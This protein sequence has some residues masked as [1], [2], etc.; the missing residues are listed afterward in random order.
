MYN[1]DIEF[2]ELKDEDIITYYAQLR[3][4]R[5]G[6]IRIERENLHGKHVIHNYGHGGA[7][8]SLAPSCSLEAV[9]LALDLIKP[10]NP[11]AIIGSGISGLMVAHHIF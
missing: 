3:P 11:I 10:N 1:T 4:Y 8:I 6:G 7:G 5:E 9:K 2:P